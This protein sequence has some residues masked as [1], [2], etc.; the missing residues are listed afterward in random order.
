MMLIIG[1]KLDGAYQQNIRRQVPENNWGEGD[2]RYP[3]QEQRAELAINV[4]QV[5]LRPRSINRNN[6]IYN[7]FVTLINN[8]NLGA[9]IVRPIE[10]LYRRIVGEISLTNLSRIVTELYNTYA[11]ENRN[12]NR[13]NRRLLG[14]LENILR[15]I[16]NLQEERSNDPLAIASDEADRL[17]EQ[18]YVSP[19]MQYAVFSYVHNYLFE[20]NVVTGKVAY[21]P[22][23][24]Q[25]IA[26]KYDDETDIADAGID[27]PGRLNALHAA[28]EATRT[29]KFLAG[30]EVA[31]ANP[32]NIQFAPT[33]SQS[34]V[35]FM[36]AIDQNLINALNNREAN[37]LNALQFTPGYNSVW[38][39]IPKNIISMFSYNTNQTRANIVNAPHL[40]FIINQDDLN[41]RNHVVNISDAIMKNIIKNYDYK[42]KINAQEAAILLF[43]QCFIAQQN[44]NN[45]DWPLFCTPPRSP[46]SAANYVFDRFEIGG[47]RY[48]HNIDQIC[49]EIVRQARMHPHNPDQAHILLLQ[50]RK[51]IQTAMFIAN[52]NSNFNIVYT[53]PSA[54]TKYLNDIVYHLSLYD[55]K[56]DGLC[57]DPTLGATAADQARGKLWNAITMI[58]TVGVTVGVAAVAYKGIVA[59]GKAVN[60]AV[61]NF[62]APAPQPD[63]PGVKQQSNSPITISDETIARLANGTPA[64]NALNNNLINL[65]VNNL[66]ANQI[67]L[68]NQISSNT[69]R[70]NALQNSNNTGNA[71]IVNSPESDKGENTIGT[72]ATTG[73]ILSDSIKSFNNLFVP[74]AKTSEKI[75]QLNA[76][77]ASVQTQLIQT[78]KEYANI[79]SKGLHNPEVVK[80]EEKI[81][82]LKVQLDAIRQH[83]DE[84][85]A[86][87]DSGALDTQPPKNLPMNLMYP[88]TKTQDQ[89]RKDLAATKLA[90]KDLATKD[91]A[92][93]ELAANL[94]QTNDDTNPIIRY[95]MQSFHPL[96][97]K[98]FTESKTVPDWQVGGDAENYGGSNISINDAIT[99]LNILAPIGVAKAGYNVA[100]TGITAAGGKLG[101]INPTKDAV[102]V[103]GKIVNKQLLPLPT[104]TGPAA[105][106]AIVDAP[107][108]TALQLAKGNSTAGVYSKKTTQLL[109]PAGKPPMAPLPVGLTGIATTGLLATAPGASDIASDSH[110]YTENKI[111]A[112]AP[113][114]GIESLFAQPEVINMDAQLALPEH[115]D[116][117]PESAMQPPA[118][119]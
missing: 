34:L 57:Q 99:T 10:D 74:P 19:E 50:I 61:N 17:I 89:L 90:T 41:Y 25:I 81:D 71:T 118:S 54:V 115:I 96:D 70:I 30:L 87:E 116:L 76:Q 86:L 43:K 2:Y 47:N 23:V 13:V 29:A 97:S 53:F 28:L 63:K 114:Y 21:M 105:G 75:S 36:P 93:K 56:L 51:A 8:T 109:L 88:T 6:N 107:K 67:D 82:E 3:N 40:E 31:Y 80:V 94:E 78:E 27:A 44:F 11:N 111:Q 58:V 101:L 103:G 104:Y 119:A 32:R 106:K 45:N 4:Y 102:I 39:W 33:L 98:F 12:G 14:T 22:T 65:N 72:I 62:F 64:M 1:Q 20:I 24:D 68:Q 48:A 46:I 84:Q 15:E 95:L 5:A 42:E 117:S 92:T 38:S 83:N 60:N 18:S 85:K 112:L 91:L 52:K 69:D 113:T 35:S 79:K 108:Q 59:G 77:Y 26:G 55:H 7:Q 110:F 66:T 73:N 49:N 100:K 16:N 37:I 9:D